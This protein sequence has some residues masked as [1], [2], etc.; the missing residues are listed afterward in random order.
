MEL[1]SQ[2]QGHPAYRR[3]MGE[4]KQALEQSESYAYLLDTFL[5]HFDESADS[6]REQSFQN[7]EKKL[8]K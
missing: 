1:R 7:E 3:L 5:K 6:S 8:H 2:P 4:L